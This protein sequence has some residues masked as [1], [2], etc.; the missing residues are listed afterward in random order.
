MADT[1]F[2]LFGIRHHGPGCARS[3][4]AALEWLQPDC[5]LIEGPPEGEAVLPFLGDAAMVPPVAM[6]VFNPDDAKQAAFYP[7]A[8]FSPEWQALRYGVQHGVPV[9][10]MD[11]PVAQ[12]FALKMADDS[13]IDVEDA[14]TDTDTDTDETLLLCDTRDPLDWLGRAA[15]YDSGE[16][17]WNHLVEERG[18]QSQQ[19]SLDIFAAIDR[20]SVV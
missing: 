18:K 9:R 20:K 17:W 3:L 4:L 1:P 11:L 10:L 7:Y 13:D 12:S 14:D 2:F 16:S 6:L 5:L 8:E 19:Q 15:G